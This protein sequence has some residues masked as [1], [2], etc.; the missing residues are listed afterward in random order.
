[1]STT[2]FRAP[3]QLNKLPVKGLVPESTSSAPG[4][5]VDGQLWWDTTNS[6]LK[7]SSG[8]SWKDPLARANHTGTQTASTI[9]DFNTA[10]RTNRLDQMAAPTAA[11][12]HGGQRA[13]NAADPTTATDLATK[14]YVDN[15]RA[16]IQVKDP[17][18]VVASSNINLS[19][20]PSSIDSVTLSSTGGPDGLGDRFL[21]ANQTTGTQNGLYRYTG[22]GSAAVRTS[23]ADATGEVVDGT[24]VAVAEGTAA[25][26][27]Y[28]QTATPSGS[29]GSWTQTWTQFNT[30]G[31]TYSA[32]N[33]L[34]LSTTTFSVLAA[35]GSISVSGSG[36][37]VGTVPV[38]KGGTNATTASAARANLGT[39]GKYSADVG[40]L[41]GGVALNI[42]HSLGTT[43]ILEPSL[44][45]TATGE[46][47][48]AKFIVVDSNTVSVTVAVSASSGAYRVTVVG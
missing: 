17:V 41:T 16:G 29:P 2:D 5:P 44:K 3:L 15:A 8:G 13:S 25:G 23:D 38:S 27:Q 6:L 19:S 33:G 34:Q 22:S 21:A 42:T 43:D 32:G 4:S 36:V 45:D 1:M 39:V 40:A 10:V 20:L 35:D 30:G 26:S 18:R 12:D 14:Q 47:V 48:G 28:I 24:L 37:T 9:S 7:W 11:L 31:T 46:L